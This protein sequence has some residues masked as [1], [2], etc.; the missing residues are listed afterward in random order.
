FRFSHD[1]LYELGECDKCDSGFDSF[2]AFLIMM[3]YTQFDEVSW[4]MANDKYGW[5]AP[6]P[7]SITEDGPHYIEWECLSETLHSQDLLP[8]YAAFEM[9]AHQTGNLFLDTNLYEEMSLD[10]LYIEINAETIPMLV[11]EW[12]IAR[13]IWDVYDIAEGM[14]EQDPGLYAQLIEIWNQ[15]L[16]KADTE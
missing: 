9:V 5:N 3:M 11:S 2:P 8:F 7:R 15:C 13:S 1:D 6:A 12:E 4:M 14:I 16:R 10:E